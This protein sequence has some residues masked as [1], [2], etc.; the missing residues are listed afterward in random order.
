[1]AAP[2]TGTDRRYARRRIR[3]K[4]F[5]NCRL[6][7]AVATLRPLLEAAVPGRFSVAVTAEAAGDVDPRAP[8]RMGVATGLRT[9]AVLALDVAE[10][11]RL[12]K[13]GEGL[14]PGKRALG[15]SKPFDGRDLVPA[16]I[17]DRGG[18]LVVADRMA[19][20]TARRRPVAGGVVDSVRSG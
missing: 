3:R 4:A 19:R 5:T 12:R 18:E 6:E 8:Q 17:L 10:F 13:I 7:V 15:E 9:V 16:A 2:T 20:T 14:R 1:M 11:R